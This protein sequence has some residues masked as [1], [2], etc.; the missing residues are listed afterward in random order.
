MLL[1]SPLAAFVIGASHSPAVARRGLGTL[2]RLP[3]LPELVQRGPVLQDIGHEAYGNLTF[4][5]GIRSY[6][7][8]GAKGPDPCTGASFAGNAA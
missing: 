1:V 3:P 7:P 6:L 4:R 8:R 5:T 2:T